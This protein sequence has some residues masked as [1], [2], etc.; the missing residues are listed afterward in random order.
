MVSIMND[1]FSSLLNQKKTKYIILD[2]IIPDLSGKI[3]LYIDLRSVFSSFFSNRFSDEVILSDFSYIDIMAEIIN[4]AGHY[5]G[6]FIKNQLPV[7]YINCFIL[8]SD[9]I[10]PK[11][12]E[13]YPEYKKSFYERRNGMTSVISR[14]NTKFTKCLEAIPEI[15]MCIPKIFYV[16]TGDIDTYDSLRFFIKPTD[17]ETNIIITNDVQYFPYIS[18]KC[19]TAILTMKGD[20][21]T[22][23]TSKNVYDYL[24]EFNKI[25]QDNDFKLG[26]SQILPLIVMSGNKK[27][28]VSSIGRIGYSN[29]SQLLNKLV[30]KG[31]IPRKGLLLLSDYLDLIDKNADDFKLDENKRKLFERN[32][33]LFTV[34]E[35]ELVL[36][37]VE[38]TFLENQLSRK[39]DSFD[40][41]N[42]FNHDLFSKNILSLDFM[43]K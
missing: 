2:K 31:I 19:R 9:K 21:S 32:W 6:Y 35:Q 1:L 11:K 37:T 13:I 27:N 34:R 28:D 40:T 33:K 4:T 17:D 38:K 24:T 7:D 26:T 15:L 42:S 10:S 12:L 30:N 3:N 36:T 20:N 25:T 18:N 8:Y 16:N 22:F 29:G 39:L 14:F 41:Y 5:C 23:L 43:F